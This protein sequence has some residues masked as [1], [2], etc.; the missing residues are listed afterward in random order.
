MSS[1]S[2]E[3]QFKDLLIIA[4]TCVIALA[5]MAAVAL[6]VYLM[7]PTPHQAPSKLFGEGRASWDSL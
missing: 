5:I 7:R 4:L 6:V 3:P 2:R 1:R